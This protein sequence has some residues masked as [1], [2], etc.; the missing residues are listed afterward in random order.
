MTFQHFCHE[1]KWH[2]HI[3][4]VFLNI[5]ISYFHFSELVWIC[6]EVFKV[7]VKW[8][9]GKSVGEFKPLGQNCGFFELRGKTHGCDPTKG[10]NVIVPISN[11]IHSVG[12][13]DFSTTGVAKRPPPSSQLRVQCSISLTSENKNK[14][15][16]DL[17]PRSKGIPSSTHSP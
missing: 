9:K 4:D 5:L 13:W 1:C 15:R 7:T 2:A 11:G 6:Y 8:S 16:K 14:K 3:G 10:S 12:G 17:I